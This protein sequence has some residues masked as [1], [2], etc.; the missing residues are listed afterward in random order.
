MTSQRLAKLKQHILLLNISSQM[1]S[2]IL[3]FQ[4][5]IF[6]YFV[7]PGLLSMAEAEGPHVGQSVTARWSWPSTKRE[8]AELGSASLCRA[9]AAQVVYCW[10]KWTVNV[11]INCM[12]YVSFH[13]FYN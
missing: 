7:R 9:A 4:T 10:R 11:I 8:A 12:F 5:C 6:K 13:L 3:S 1:C 2:G